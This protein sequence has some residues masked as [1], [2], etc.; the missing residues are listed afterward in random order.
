[1]AWVCDR[2]VFEKLFTRPVSGN[3]TLFFLASSSFKIHCVK[4]IQLRSFFWSVFSIYSVSLRIQF[5]CGEIQTRRK[6]VF[7]HFSRSEY[8]ANFTQLAI[9]NKPRIYNP[10]KKLTLKLTKFRKIFKYS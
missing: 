4:S 1:M 6:S 7:G 9:K 3:K 2:V 8:L 10:S 5:G